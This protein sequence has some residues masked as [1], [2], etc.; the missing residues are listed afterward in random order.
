VFIKLFRVHRLSSDFKSLTRAHD[1][2]KVEK[3]ELEQD[4]LLTRSNSAQLMVTNNQLMLQVKAGKDEVRVKEDNPCI[5]ESS[6]S[7]IF[8]LSRSHMVFVRA[9]DLGSLYYLVVIWFCKE[10]V[11]VNFTWVHQFI[12]IVLLIPKLLG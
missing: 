12:E 5:C 2:M 11:I 9:L 1:L 10:L 3:Q 6:R 4:L 7:R 8:I